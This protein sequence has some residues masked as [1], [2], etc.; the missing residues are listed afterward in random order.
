[1]KE[2]DYENEI[3]IDA[4]ALDIE[5]ADQ[6]ATFMKYAKNAAHARKDLDEIKQMLDIKKADLDQTIRKDPDKF[7]IEKITEGAILSAILTDKDYQ[8][9]TQ[10]YLNAKYETDMAQSAVSAFNQKKDMLEVLVKLHGQSYFA[11]P[12][13]PRDLSKERELKQKLSNIGV[14]SRLTRNKR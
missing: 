14:A 4:D 7:G 2:L 12:S 10:G 3:K 8:R 5:C 11:G 9:V 13:V 1:M 6:A